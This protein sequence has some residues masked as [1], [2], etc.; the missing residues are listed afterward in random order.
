MRGRQLFVIIL[1]AAVVAALVALGAAGVFTD[2]S[3]GSS[4]HALDPSQ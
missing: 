4:P 3:G 1:V 2:D